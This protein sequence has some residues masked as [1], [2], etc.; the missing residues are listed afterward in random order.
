MTRRKNTEKEPM[1]Q[2]RAVGYTRVST[3][4]QLD[5]RSLHDQAKVIKAQCKK[6]GWDLVEIYE[7]KGRSA[8]GENFHTRPEFNRMMEDAEAGQFNFLVVASSD[9]IGR[10]SAGAMALA[11]K[12]MGL[13]ILLV[14]IQDPIDLTNPSGKAQ[15]G[16]AAIFNEFNSDIT[17]QKVKRT[18]KEKR[19]EGLAWGRGPY[20]YQMCDESCARDDDHLYWHLNSKKVPIVAK[21]FELY[22]SGNYS[23]ND[24]AIWLNDRGH[25]TNGRSVD[26]PGAQIE[27]NFFTSHSVS[28]ILKNRCYIGMIKDPESETGE[29]VGR[30]ADI[31]GKDIFDRVKLRLMKNAGTR[32]NAGNKSKEPTILARIVRC[33]KCESTYQCTRQGDKRYIYL[34]MKRTVNSPDCFCVGKSFNSRHVEYDLDTLLQ[35]FSLTEDWQASM[36]ESLGQDPDAE[37]VEKERKRIQEMMR[38]TAELYADL[39]INRD[40]YKTRRDQF[41]SDLASLQIP[42]RDEIID[43]GQYL[44]KNLGTLWSHATNEEKNEILHRIFDAIN[45]DGA[46]RRI[47]SLVPKES[48]AIPIRAMAER[49]DVRFEELDNSRLL[50]GKGRFSYQLPTNPLSLVFSRDLLLLGLPERIKDRRYESYMTRGQMAAHLGISVGSV[51]SLETG[52]APSIEML[53]LLADWFDEDTPDWA[54]K[55][56]DIPGLGQR[57]KDRRRDWGMTQAELGERLGVSAAAICS[58]EQGS[59]PSM[60]TIIK[61]APWLAEAPPVKRAKLSIKSAFGKR[62]QKKRLKIAMSQRALGKHLGV[63]KDNIRNWESGQHFPSKAYAEMMEEWLNERDDDILAHRIRDKRVSLYST[64]RDLAAV[65]D[66]SLTTVK[67]WENRRAFPSSEHSVRVIKWLS[68]GHLDHRQPEKQPE[69][70]LFVLPMKARRQALGI[71]ATTLAN[72]LGVGNSK[73]YEWEAARSIPSQEA[74]QKIFTWLQAA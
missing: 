28:G 70:G 6:K 36:V 13:G 3:E 60:Q 64:Q 26:K 49:P 48:F 8:W 44:S 61:I 51:T 74:C 63:D 69:F 57:V 4:D 31:V 59:T 27:G 66:V 15:Y 68:R 50:E 40:T 32:K 17:S 21:M 33:Y 58:C 65:L 42:K 47:H 9:R 52:S 16:I 73:V 5:G 54:I 72:K 37:A 30:H 12:L 2:L 18:V 22:D 67:A 10:S 55:P 29:R 43:A 19:A 53:E 14:S 45:V 24:I 71:G 38:R 7:E 25:R 39:Q 1:R 35:R 56:S 23:T 62:I 41:E 11:D 34:R 20:G 46:A